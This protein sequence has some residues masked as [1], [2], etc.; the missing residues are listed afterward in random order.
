MARIV[1]EM[2]AKQR[3]GTPMEDSAGAR[4]E[5]RGL[6]ATACR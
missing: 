1:D 3:V 5:Q 6:R 4:A 2:L